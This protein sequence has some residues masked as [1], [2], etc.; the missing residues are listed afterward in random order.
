MQDL[1]RDQLSM[2]MG[3]T[4]ETVYA[5]VSDVTRTPDFSPEVIRCSWLGGATGPA[6]GARFKARNKVQRGP[7]WNNKP[8]VTVADPGREFAFTRT[9]IGG[10]TMLW[11]YRFDAEDAGTRVTESYEVV[12]P[13]TA[14]MWFVIER[15]C[16]RHDRRSDLR[17]GMQQTLERVRAVAES[18]QALDRAR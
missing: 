4:P 1:D 18:Q 17:Q 12:R 15:V 9:E 10:G 2:F 3:A 16:G 6:V 5:L 8:V 13:M 14:F 7:G 11:Q